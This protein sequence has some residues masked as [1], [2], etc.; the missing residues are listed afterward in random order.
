MYITPGELFFITPGELFISCI[1]FGQPVAR[2][3]E[4][5]KVVHAACEHVVRPNPRS[6]SCARLRFRVNFLN[7]S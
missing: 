4:G 1:L 2:A 5:S 6:H 7:T 3:I